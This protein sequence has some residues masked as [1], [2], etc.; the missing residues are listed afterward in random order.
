MAMINR[1]TEYFKT[2]EVK[3]A[4]QGS[5]VSVLSHFPQL[6]R[7]LEKAGKHVPCPKTGEGKDSFRLYSK[8]LTLRGGGVHNDPNVGSMSDGFSLLMWLLDMSF[9][10]VVAEVALV[11]GMQPH[12]KRAARANAYAQHKGKRAQTEA[13][14]SAQAQARLAAGNGAQSMALPSTVNTVTH[15]QEGFAQQA[16]ST[17]AS[18]LDDNASAP[19]QP[20]SHSVTS[21]EEFARRVEAK[22]AKQSVATAGEQK[23]KIEKVWGETLP[24]SSPS[25]S[26]ARRYLG[27]RGIAMSSERFTRLSEGNSVRFHPALPYYAERDV[28]V[29]DK[30]GQVTLDSK[31]WPVMEQKIVKVDAYPA[32]I[33]AIRDNHG[34]IVTLH[35]TY[36]SPNGNGKAA[37]ECPRKMMSVPNTTTAT[38]SA[39][40]LATP[41]KGIL[42]VAEGLETA[43]SAFHA[44]GMPTWSCVNAVL[45]AAF[46]PPQN[47]HTVVVW[48]DKDRS[49][50]GEI[51]ADQLQQR[52]AKR[53][54]K[55]ITIMP[56]FGIPSQDKGIDWNDVL[57][58]YGI[59]G[60]PN[61]HTIMS[62]IACA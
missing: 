13:V 28:P 18:A 50:A 9:Q 34:E 39:I 25:A 19:R 41:H 21:R 54:I 1:D 40:P 58:R 56:A 61:T 27:T 11:L 45:L 48:A 32:V 62:R 57:M 5:W 59:G 55:V 12:K 35:R 37:V 26:V 6:S 43:L 31:G 3:A 47:V 30:N 53:G 22:L 29:L 2:E 20:E 10:E 49:L 17:F 51:A 33:L 38:G 24:L 23:R 8:D 36:L 44:T 52:L 7:A 4:A 16:A 14:S 46:E 60:F 15:P 42:G